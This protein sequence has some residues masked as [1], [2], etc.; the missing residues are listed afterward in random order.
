MVTIYNIIYYKTIATIVT[1]GTATQ[2][3]KYV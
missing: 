3:K 1:I 2:V